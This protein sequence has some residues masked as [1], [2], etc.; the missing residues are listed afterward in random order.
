MQCLSSAGAIVRPYFH[1]NPLQRLR[2]RVLTL[3]AVAGEL[4]IQLSSLARRLPA[5]SR[6]VFPTTDLDVLW[7]LAHVV[8]KRWWSHSASVI[9][10]WWDRLQG[11]GY[12]LPLET[13][14]V[15]RVAQVAAS[16]GSLI[17]YF[18]H[19]ATIADVITQNVGQPVASLPLMHEFAPPPVRLDLQDGRPLVSM[20][21]ELRDEKG[22][23]LFARAIS[24]LTSEC[25]LLV[26]A[27]PGE[28]ADEVVRNHLVE[29]VRLRGGVVHTTRRSSSEY[30]AD[31]RLSDISVL[32]Y[33]PSRYRH[34]TSG[35]LTE[36]Y[37]AG[38]Y[39]VV[40][41][42]TWLAGEVAR[43]GAG[44][45]FEPWSAEALASAIDLAVHV[46]PAHRTQLDMIAQRVVSEHS[47]TSVLQTLLTG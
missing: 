30:A 9:M 14:M 28:M 20:V 29:A 39:P 43:V 23:A 42:G 25:R 7:A 4:Y 27:A 47:P 36:L 24:L 10:F 41:S 45:T 38:V 35:V 34:R 6:L 3:P 44:Q 21:G 13:W 18:A 37:G 17:H 8:Q 15:R 12:R 31:I 32:P 19:S 1:C 11:V 26:H 40:S 5:N 16:A 2:A 33:E 46:L 22:F